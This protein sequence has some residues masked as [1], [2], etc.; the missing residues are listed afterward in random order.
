M[1]VRLYSRFLI[2]ACL[3]MML[4][5]CGT[6]S[7]DEDDAFHKEVAVKEIK[8][9]PRK[10]EWSKSW[11]KSLSFNKKTNNL[12]ERL[13][14]RFSL[15]ID[16]GNPRVA[17]YIEYYQQN[18][19]HIRRMTERAQPYLYHV[20]EEL[21]RRN[22]PAEL[23][24]LPI[25]ESGYDPF[26]L[27]RAGASGLWQIIPS[28]G[29]HLGLIQNRQYDGRRDLY[30]STHAALNY[31]DSLNTLFEED[32]LLSLAA[33]NS[34]E[35][36]VSRAISKNRLHSKQ[37]DY[38][39]L[40]LP[41]ETQ[42]YVPRFLALCA[43][44]REPEKYGI[45][46][47]PVKNTP[48]ITTV[49]LNKR[50]KLASAAKLADMPLP[51]LQRLNAGHTQAKSAQSVL[52]ALRLPAEKADMFKTRLAAF[53]EAPE[54]V[55]LASK[56]KTTVLKKQTVAHKTSKKPCGRYGTP[57]EK[58][59]YRA[60]LI[61]KND[62]TVTAHALRKH[63]VKSGESLWSI[64]KLYGISVQQLRRANANLRRALKPGDRINLV[65]L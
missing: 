37:T 59:S 18:P 6:L 31:L 46:L 3:G 24:L 61:A 17:Q 13:R 58:P 42:H 33:Y 44:I 7:P 51:T 22:L 9:A 43:I 40:H 53:T 1:I 49:S 64:S 26:A 28:T 25:I 56:H 62:K 23:S 27:S 20:V 50:V 5:A 41:Q 32:W 29:Q 65:A 12:W 10:K 45:N 21:D 4:T 11:F 52:S 2:L 15:D 55:V 48:F 54:P 38:W 47:Y 57:C 60:H 35:G 34:G 8:P 16:T 30:D 63:T 19:E 39:S 14:S 36:T